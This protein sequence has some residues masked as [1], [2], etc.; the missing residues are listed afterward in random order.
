[1]FEAPDSG[2]DYGEMER[3]RCRSREALERTLT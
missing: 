2:G 3:L 1:M